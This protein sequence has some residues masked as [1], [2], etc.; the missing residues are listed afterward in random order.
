[1]IKLGNYEILDSKKDA[2]KLKKNLEKIGFISDIVKVRV[3]NY[4]RYVVY[5]GGVHYGLP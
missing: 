1:M 3:K 4:R 2:K 5:I